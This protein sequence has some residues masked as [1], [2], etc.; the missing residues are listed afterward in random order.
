MPE[1]ATALED[2]T[3]DPFQAF[4]HALGADRV[5]NPFPKFAELQRQAPVIKGGMWQHFDLFDPTAMVYQE[6]PVYTALSYDAVTQVLRPAGSP[7]SSQGYR[8]TMGIVMGHS[9]LEMDEPEHKGYRELLEQAFSKR[10]MEQWEVEVI[11]PTIH[12][13]IDQF[14]ERGH[15]DLV[16]EFTFPFPVHVITGLLGLPQEDLR[17]FHRWAIELI[18]VGADPARGLQAS[19]KLHDYLIEVIDERRRERREDLISVLAHAELNGQRLGDEEICAFLRLLL[20]A[21]A[22]TTYRSSSNLLFGLLSHPD[23]LDAVRKDRSLLPQAIEEGLR[24]ESPLT[25]IIRVAVVDTELCGVPI[26]AGAAVMVCTASANRDEA[27][28]ENPEAFDIFRKRFPPVAFG[29]GAH[30][31]LGQHLAR[32]ETSTALN[33]LMDRLPNLRLDPEAEDVHIS[34]LMF[35]SPTTLPVLFG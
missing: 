23:Q 34:G 24:W 2:E 9:I 22:E 5:R 29:F 8:D 4:D 20:P 3:Y 16:R 1:E 19:Q 11:S 28:W 30:V 21:G 31:C 33:A 14:V 32:M 18:N 12:H 27:R 26:P 17:Q 10:A 6:A 15:A 35:R 13:F 7:F 25:S